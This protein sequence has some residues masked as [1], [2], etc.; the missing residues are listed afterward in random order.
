MQVD[1]A[2]EVFQD[3]SELTKTSAWRLFEVSMHGTYYSYSE[4]GYNGRPVDVARHC[5]VEKSK[6]KQSG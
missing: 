5:G 4:Q 3:Q 2:F 6:K 1:H